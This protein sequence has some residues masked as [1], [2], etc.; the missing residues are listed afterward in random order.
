MTAQ[1][2]AKDSLET[3][4]ARRGNV[5]R[6]EGDGL[7]SLKVENG[8]VDAVRVF[9]ARTGEVDEVAYVVDTDERRSHGVERSIHLLES[10]PETLGVDNSRHTR[11]GEGGEGELIILGKYKGLTLT[12]SNPIKTVQVLK[13]I[14]VHPDGEVYYRK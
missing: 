13:Y 3:P 6:R 10:P 7:V 14:P 8:V 12:P 1:A 5:G 9:L 2:G 4:L 11:G